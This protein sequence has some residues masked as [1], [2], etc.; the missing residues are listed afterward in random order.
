[1]YKALRFELNNDGDWPQIQATSLQ[2]WRDGPEETIWPVGRTGKRN[3]GTFL[4]AFHG[5]PCWTVEE[6]ENFRDAFQ[7]Y[8]VTLSNSKL[9]K[10][11]K[12]ERVE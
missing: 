7:S 12:L 3:G 9:R 11:G 6:V 4:K 1:M 8:G 2:Q 5:A 10:V